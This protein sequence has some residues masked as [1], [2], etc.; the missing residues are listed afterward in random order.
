MMVW[1]RTLRAA[2]QL[3]S[4]ERHVAEDQ[5]VALPQ[6]V[7]R[8][9]KIRRLLKACEGK[10]FDERRDTAILRLFIDSGMRRAP[11]WRGSA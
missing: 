4:V 9:D 6:H 3:Q 7:G 1:E 5:G 10:G 2:L 8:N 11:S